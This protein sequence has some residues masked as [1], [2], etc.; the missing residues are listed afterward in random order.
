M[1]FWIREIGGWLL[2]LLALYLLRYG[3]LFVLDLETPRIIE[4]AVVS[5]AG[6][7]VLKAGILLI[8]MSTAAAVPSRKTWSLE[9]RQLPHTATRKDR[10][11][12]RNSPVMSP[13]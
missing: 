6:L 12:T 2:V 8:R 13:F 10:G 4:A 7:G 3:L 11:S 1:F 5:F 9:A